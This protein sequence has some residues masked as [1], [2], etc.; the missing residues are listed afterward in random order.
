MLKEKTL[1]LLAGGLGSRISEETYNKP[2]PMIKLGN[3]PMIWHIMKYYS[4]FKVNK[5]IILAGYKSEVI[6]DFFLNYHY[7]RSSF[8]IDLKNNKIRI[9]KNDNK[10]MKIGILLYLIPEMKQILVEE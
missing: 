9:L 5:F 8:S 10:K 1:V 4:H 3:M 2:K 6:K 7:Y